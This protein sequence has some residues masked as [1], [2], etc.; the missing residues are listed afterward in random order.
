MKIK[1]VVDALEMFAPL[2]LQDGFDNAGLQIGLTDAEAGRGFVVSGRNRSSGRRSH[3]AG[4][5]P[6]CITP[7][8]YF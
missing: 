2:P 1:E 5:Q 3:F 8:S 7:S 6:D 4:L